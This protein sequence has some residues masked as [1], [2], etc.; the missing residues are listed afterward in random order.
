MTMRKNSHQ[1]KLARAFAAVEKNYRPEDSEPCRL[2]LAFLSGWLQRDAP[3]AAESIQR[4]LKLSS[5]H[6]H[7]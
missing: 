3:E 2:A 7:A 4:I 5:D 6:Y 1:A